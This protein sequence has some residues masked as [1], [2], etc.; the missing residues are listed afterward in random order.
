MLIATWNVNSVRK[1]LEHLEK[2]LGYA[3]PDVLCLQETKVE[4]ELFPTAEIEAMG[5]QCH[6]HGQKTYNGVAL[7]SKAPLTDIQRGFPHLPAEHPLNLQRRLIKGT[8]DG[9]T[10]AS[11][12]MPNGEEV[13]SDKYAYK[14]AFM[15]ELEKMVEAEIKSG[16]ELILC[17]DFNVTIDDRDLYD[18]EG[19]EGGIFCSKEERAG[20]NALKEAGMVDCFRLHHE[21]AGRYSWWDFRGALFWKGKGLRI[22]HIWATKGAAKMCGEA[23]IDERPRRWKTPSDHAPVWARFG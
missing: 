4:D 15:A 7:L 23:D 12:Y 19:F 2:Y 5:Y 1:R 14:L 11:L 8:V 3:K 20:M 17:G 10:V 9:L 13:G 21:E 16:V 18:P 6:I 22:D